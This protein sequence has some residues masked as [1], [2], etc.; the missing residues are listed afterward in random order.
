MLGSSLSIAPPEGHDVATHL[1]SLETP[2]LPPPFPHAYVS[3]CASR[4]EDSTCGEGRGRSG[5][6]PRLPTAQT[7]RTT[8]VLS[9][10]S[11][12]DLRTVWCADDRRW[13]GPLSLSLQPSIRGLRPACRQSTHLGTRHKHK[14]KGIR[15]RSFQWVP[16]SLF[17]F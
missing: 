10:L 11:L 12:G 7:V 1:R 15:E 17:L 16:F 3:S 2:I 9:T 5:W 4:G 8:W 6:N 13:L 14:A